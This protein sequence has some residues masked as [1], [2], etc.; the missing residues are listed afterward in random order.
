MKSAKSDLDSWKKPC[1]VS[2]L[3]YRFKTDV[4]TIQ[5]LAERGIVVRLDRNQYDPWK[6]T[7][8]YIQP[9]R[10]EAAKRLGCSVEEL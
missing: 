9:L 3:A 6:S 1:S 8:R 2:E 5:H 4:R 10:E 7:Q